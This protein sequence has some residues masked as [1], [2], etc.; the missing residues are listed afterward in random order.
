MAAE[1]NASSSLGAYFSLGNVP[2]WV[3]LVLLLTLGVVGYLHH[4]PDAIARQIQ[5]AG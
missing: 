5:A 4:Q 1:H 3:S 2:L